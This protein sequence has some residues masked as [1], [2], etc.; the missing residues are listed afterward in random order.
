MK[1]TKKRNS[2]IA[3]KMSLMLTVLGL[4]TW[5]MCILNIM[6]FGVL[7]DYNS[8]LHSAVLE[9][10][11]SSDATE[12]YTEL[13]DKIEGLFE[14]ME[15]KIDGTYLFDVILGG[16]ALLITVLAV[17]IAMKLIVKPTKHVSATLEGV[18]DSIKKN[19]GDLTLRAKV[20]NHD[21]IGRLASDINGFIEFLQGYMLT[22]RENADLLQKSLEV[23]NGQVEES[24]TSV[25]NVSSATEQMA[26]SMQEMSATIQ[27]IANGSS[28]VF[29]KVQ[30][31]SQNAGTSAENI[32]QI[33]KRVEEMRN[34]VLTSKET[35]TN[36]IEGMQESLEASVR[37]SASVKQIQ[38][39]TNDILSIA[40]QTN[41]L[42]LNAS[43]EA[44]RAGEA[45]KGFAVVAEE[46]R[47][48]AD[49]SQHTANNIQEISNIVIGAV[50]KLADNSQ[51]LL[52]FL[53]STVMKDYDEFVDIMNQY[54]ND[55]EMLNEVFDDFAG[56]AADME[57]TMKTMNTGINDI[58][59]T[60]DESAKAVTTV[61]A[62]ASDMVAA[63]MDIQTETA[64]NKN[65]ADQM[66][67]TV[68]RFKNL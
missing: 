18:M 31:I 19:E 16:V 8:R 25:T 41:L 55:T 4:I 27:E 29:E 51:E 26:A 21:E 1:S 58:A 68:G 53:D 44:A 59:I 11:N 37:D 60:V 46:I 62:D 12:G 63:M 50:S 20:K 6:A 54:N 56:K 2:S 35:T 61:A 23:V 43:I 28:E 14:Y 36:V 24:N 3:L 13:I 15:I 47:V 64:N 65:I 30:D 67:D 17:I 42:A 33:Q 7:R 32:A 49:N 9:Y 66:L 40:S 22:M 5:V 38:E 10:E 57:A 34:S 39:L 52:G 48:L 45:G